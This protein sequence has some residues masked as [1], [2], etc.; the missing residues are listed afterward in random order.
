MCYSSPRHDCF[1]ARLLAMVCK[2]SECA[3]GRGAEEGGGDRQGGGVG[4]WGGRKEGVVF[5]K[6]KC[7]SALVCVV[8]N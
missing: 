6:H 4:G 8:C 7:I 3:E 1:G 2:V 5:L